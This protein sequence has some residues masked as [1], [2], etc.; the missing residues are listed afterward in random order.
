MDDKDRSAEM[1]AEMSLLILQYLEIYNRDQ[2]NFPVS[3]QIGLHSGEIIAGVTGIR[4]F[5]IEMYDFNFR[6]KCPTI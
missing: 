6:Q 4:Q 3:V 2:N 1:A 5:A